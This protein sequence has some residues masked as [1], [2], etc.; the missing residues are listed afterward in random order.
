MNSWSRGILCCVSGLLLFMKMPPLSLACCLTQ[1]S[2]L[3]FKQRK[4]SIVL[5]GAQSVL[6]GLITNYTDGASFMKIFG[7]NCLSFVWDGKGQ[8]S[9]CLILLNLG[10][11][12]GVLCVFQWMCLTCFPWVK[13]RH[14]CCIP[15]W[16]WIGFKETCRRDVS[17]PEFAALSF[18]CSNLNAHIRCHL[19]SGPAACFLWRLCP[20]KD[21]NTIT[22]KE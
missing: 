13:S 3:Q 22:E 10:L 21:R 15:F 7:S 17:L 1:G 18:R 19:I 6:P 4:K 11:C 9:L 20:E 14:P 5:W 8:D 12:I 16:C 2:R